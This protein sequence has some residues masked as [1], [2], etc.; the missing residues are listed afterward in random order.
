M[1]AYCNNPHHAGFISVYGYTPPFRPSLSAT[2]HT[3][4]ALFQLMAA[5][6]LSDLQF[7]QQ[8]TPRRP[9]FS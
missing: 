8:S 9:Y 5:P 3:T 1:P 6:L 4:P 2:I 7:L